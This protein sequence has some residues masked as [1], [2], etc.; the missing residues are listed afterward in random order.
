MSKI[1]GD[2]KINNKQTNLFHLV[3]KSPNILLVYY[4][5]TLL[6]SLIVIHFNILLSHIL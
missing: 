3:I 4:V 1:L 2:I 5:L 6:S